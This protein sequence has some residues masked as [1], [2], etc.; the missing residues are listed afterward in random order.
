[1]RSILAVLLIFASAAAAQETQPS[2]KI[3][4][5]AFGD[6]YWVAENH[7]ES[8]ENRNGFWIRRIFLSVDQILGPS[9][10]AR[11]RFEANQPGDFTSSTTLQPFVKDAWLRWKQSDALTVIAG[12]TPDPVVQSAEDFWGYRPL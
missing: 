3:S 7:N 5:V 4:V 6:Y 11:L 8:I 9:L 2:T 1:M 12:M 10:T